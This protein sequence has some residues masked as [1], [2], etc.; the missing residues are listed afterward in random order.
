MIGILEKAKCEGWTDLEVIERVK[1]GEVALYEVIMRRYNQR[2]YRVARSILRNDGEAE[3]VMQDAYVR[4][5]QHLSQYSG[6]APF[7]TWLTRIAVN[8]ALARLRLRNRNQQLE[9]D[10]RNGD[11]PMHVAD[12]APDPERSAS[13][14]EMNHFL[15]EAVLDLPEQYRTVVMLR[16]I[17]E[18]STADTAAALDLTEENVKVR[19]HRA[20]GMMREWLFDRVGARAK[21]AFPFM[22]ARCDRVVEQVFAKIGERDSI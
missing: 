20:R 7:A 22:G 5:Y 3:D 8:E 16:D 13:V 14:A 6:A 21:Q 4:A 1:A 10:D 18:L 11:G 15:E 19:L 12:T 9:D 2:L 17:E